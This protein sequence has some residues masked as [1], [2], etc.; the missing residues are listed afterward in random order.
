M[1]GN[2]HQTL[3][4]KYVKALAW[5]V[6]EATKLRD[7]DCTIEGVIRRQRRTCGEDL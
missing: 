3:L 7:E 5:S 4:T 1:A 6:E 2:P